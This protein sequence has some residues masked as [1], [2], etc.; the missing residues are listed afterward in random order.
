M[1]QSPPDIES[2]CV[3]ICVIDEESGLCTGCNRTRREIASWS[4][5]SNAERRK[6]MSEL[7]ARQKQTPSGNR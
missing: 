4:S 3:K 2:P 1:P 7:T 6:I 5:I